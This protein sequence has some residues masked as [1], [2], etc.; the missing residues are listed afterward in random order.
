[1]PRGALVRQR[2]VLAVFDG[3]DELP[4][5]TQRRAMRVLSQLTE[6]DAWLVT[7]RTEAFAN[8]PATHRAGVDA[9]MTAQPLSPREAHTYLHRMVRD[10]ERWQ[11]VLTELADESDTPLAKALRTPLTLWL[12]SQTYVDT[13]ADP[14]RLT[15]FAD[16]E[17]VH[18]HLLT[19]L[20]P[21][22]LAARLAGDSPF[23]ARHRWPADRAH[24]WLTTLARSLTA[25]GTTEL[26]WWQ[27][28]DL[29]PRHP[30][31]VLA[32]I[33][34]VAAGLLVG[35]AG[36]LTA[37][38]QGLAIAAVITVAPAVA[39]AFCS[40]ERPPPAFG[41]FQLRQRVPRLLDHLV[42]G[43]VAGLVVG[44]LFLVSAQLGQWIAP[45]Y[46]PP[47]TPP[48]AFTT[49]IGLGVGVGFFRWAGVATRLDD[50]RTPATV[51][52]ADRRLTLFIA[53]T[54]A[55]AL[56]AFTT[57]AL[58]SSVAGPAGFAMGLAMFPVWA[59]WV[60]FG[61]MTPGA[62]RGRRTGH[63]WPGYVLSVAWAAAS[64]RLPWR[65]MPFL[66][67][68]HRLGILKQVGAVYQF[69]HTDV[70]DILAATSTRS[71][72]PDVPAPGGTRTPRRPSSGRS[73]RW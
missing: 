69:R 18:R 6:N 21:S 68:M 50:A 72:R 49:G 55:A 24:H 54:I 56:C 61:A 31:A 41:S 60:A 4:P 25:R 28:N 51:L 5:D 11:P 10:D 20:V 71:T 36:V 22:V 7:S 26:A 64:G 3:L 15:T 53:G 42:K 13:P 16:P 1:M 35:V 46:F 9:T 62:A 66:A 14:V 34:A 59:V 19:Q 17:Q 32:A 2:R 29:G 44:G 65:L 12:V 40:V 30:R 33:L 67:D 73:R 38:G 63:A 37:G 27:L 45:G 58:S 39:A 70:R 57:Y 8:L 43:A 52:R 23:H 48:A 47:L